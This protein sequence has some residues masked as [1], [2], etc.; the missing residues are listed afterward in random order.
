MTELDLNLINYSLTEVE[1]L[2]KVT[3]PYS[4]NDVLKNEKMIV[5]VISKDVNYPVEKKAKFIEFM[6][7]AKLRLT[8]NLRKQ[9][10]KTIQNEN[11]MP[12][13]EAVVQ[14]NAPRLVNQ[15][16]VTQSGGNS[17]V[18]H[19][20]TITFNDIIDKNKRLNPVESY[21]T[22]IARGD[23]NQ[24][25]RKV[26]NQSV[27]LNS[28]F[29]EDYNNTK[30]TDF[31]LV[32]PYQF[33]N[34]LSLKLSSIQLPNVIYCFSE[35]K[36]NDLVYLKET[37]DGDVKEGSVILPD[38]NYTLTAL[39]IALTKAINE[40]LHISPP[41]FSVVADV[42]SNKLTIENNRNTFEMNFLKDIESKDFN[43]TLG[44]LLGFRKKF[45]ECSARY[46][47]EAVYVG[48]STDYVFFVLNDFNNSQTQSILAMYSK[49]YIGDNIL[50]MVPISTN[51][52]SQNNFIND[53]GNLFLEKKREYFG[54]VNLQRFKIEL[55]NQYGELVDLNSTDFS[56]TLEV[57][58]G[59]DW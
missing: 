19:P 25:K 33:K 52:V 4:L 29:R 14:Q 50:A 7:E 11:E 38:G 41:R 10:D 30:S 45:Y 56:F 57:E 5:E 43:S 51:S 18:Q 23:L 9:L 39:A 59:Y 6:K 1:T 3:P 48:T 17:F 42:A 2:L 58:V 36:M 27:V 35:E 31:T 34:V 54:P 16:S 21:P 15:V 22:D 49:S 55:R 32:L 12:D 46:T 37:G 13:E 53:A 20:E 44:W 8:R 28:V 47:A 40:Q 24:L 26:Y